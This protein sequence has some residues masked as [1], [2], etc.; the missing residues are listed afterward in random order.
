M[1]TARLQTKAQRL[2]RGSFSIESN[3]HSRMSRGGAVGLSIANTVVF[4]LSILVHSMVLGAPTQ[5]DV[6]KSIQTNVGQ[7]TDPTKFIAFL[8]GAAGLVALLALLNVRRNREVKPKVLNHHGRLLK[9]IARRIDLKPSE[10]RQLK[11]LAEQ[12]EDVSS[13]LTML[14]CPSVLTATVK[15]NVNRVDKKVILGIARKL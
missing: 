1:K 5:E 4:V 8:V 9:E 2:R 10:I 7:S 11:L 15:E 12:R 14:L 3:R 6:F 13:P